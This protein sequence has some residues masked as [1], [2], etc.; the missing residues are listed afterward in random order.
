MEHDSDDI[1]TNI[2]DKYAT[3]YDGKN[4]CIAEIIDSLSET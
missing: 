1:S 2:K 3:M 4:V